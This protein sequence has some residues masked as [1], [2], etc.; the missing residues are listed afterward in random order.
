MTLFAL[1]RETH[2]TVSCVSRLPPGVFLPVQR[3]RGEPGH[4]RDRHKNLTNQPQDRTVSVVKAK[5]AERVFV[6]EIEVSEGT[7]EK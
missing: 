4:T 1:H 5:S 7:L 3:H 2:F 6:V